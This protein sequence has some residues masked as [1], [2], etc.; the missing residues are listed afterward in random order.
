MKRLL[1]ALL[2]LPLLPAVQAA[3]GVELTADDS[4]KELSVTAQA[5][6]GVQATVGYILD[7]VGPAPLRL[8]SSMKDGTGNAVPHNATW[9]LD[10]NLMGTTT[11]TTTLLLGTVP[12]GR[13]PLVLVWSVGGQ[14]SGTLHLQAFVRREVSGEGGSASGVGGAVAPTTLRITRSALP[15]TGGA[16]ATA[17]GATPVVLGFAF[18]RR[19]DGTT[20][21][22]G[23]SIPATSSLVVAGPGG[24]VQRSLITSVRFTAELGN[25]PDGVYDYNVTA[26]EEGGRSS[27]F[28]GRLRLQGQGTG[29]PLGATLVQALATALQQPL[30]AGSTF[31]VDQDRDGRPDLVLDATGHVAQLRAL[32]QQARFLL[33]AIDGGA[34]FLLEANTGAVRPMQAVIGMPGADKSTGDTRNVQV[35]VNEKSG[36]ILVS[37]RDPHPGER[38]LGVQ[39]SDGTPL[40]GEAVWQENGFVQFVDDPATTYTLL[41]TVPPPPS[42]IPLGTALALLGVGLLGGALATLLLRRRIQ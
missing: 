22:W 24:A 12:A 7:L 42:G 13:H 36:W 32:R 16:S 18:D 37:V 26:R 1:A 9:R 21:S 23:T 35:A 10:G 11:G 38:L 8:L 25:L 3:D 34:L 20:L 27:S 31:L 40:P 28:A 33:Q 15:A 30:P 39:R 29:T 6:Q 14:A 17:G 5:G 19:A 41:Y 2:L 4:A